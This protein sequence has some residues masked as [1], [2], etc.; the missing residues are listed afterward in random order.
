MPRCLPRQTG[1]LSLLNTRQKPQN[2]RVPCNRQH[3]PQGAVSEKPRTFAEL[4]RNRTR[5]HAGRFVRAVGNTSV[6]ASPQALLRAP[7]FAAAARSRS[8][9]GFG[10]MS[11]RR[12]RAFAAVRSPPTRSA[13]VHLAGANGAAS[14][15]VVFAPFAQPFARKCNLMLIDAVAL[16]CE[17]QPHGIASRMASRFF[18][19]WARCVVAS[20]RRR[21]RVKRPWPALHYPMRRRVANVAPRPA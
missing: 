10:S 9:D 12:D 16:S 3:L 8:S 6:G 5:R 7:R 14:C 20:A 21:S 13:S 11:T 2:T 1:E 17:R 4:P 15:T 19:S 18:A